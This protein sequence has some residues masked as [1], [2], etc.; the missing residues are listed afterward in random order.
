M[1]RKQLPHFRSEAVDG[2]QPAS[3]PAAADPRQQQQ[4]S[5]AAAPGKTP[6]PSQPPQPVAPVRQEG[7]TVRA[8]T[9]AETPVRQ[10]ERSVAA[11]APA[12]STVEAASVLSAQALESQLFD[13]LPER[14]LSSA[15]YR[16]YLKTLRGQIDDIL[17]ERD[18]E[19]NQK[20]IVKT[21][22]KLVEMR[23]D[24]EAR[25]WLR[26]AQIGKELLTAG[27]EGE[28]KLGEEL[29]TIAAANMRANMGLGFKANLDVYEQTGSESAGALIEAL[30][31]ASL[32]QP[33]AL[34]RPQDGSS[35]PELGQPEAAPAARSPM[36][37]LNRDEE[38]WAPMGWN[39]ERSD[40][41]P[42]SS[43]GPHSTDAR[44]TGSLAPSEP[45]PAAQAAGA[46][47]SDDDEA[48]GQ[49]VVEVSLTAEELAAVQRLLALSA[50]LDRKVAQ[51][52][53]KK[54]KKSKQ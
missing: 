47:T 12:G 40:S 8:D 23:D 54:P 20:R 19:L 2:R 22:Y 10:E 39:D 34:E 33:Q 1:K 38:D 11:D 43:P 25:S 44:Q 48:E 6:A 9:S 53:K 36:E 5:A 16:R 28:A 46:S 49:D 50:D 3:T 13:D 4:P 26:V 24:F 29:H 52:D 14:P 51:S 21:S 31:Q 37:W 7:G 41:E 35:A 17:A 32:Q 42:S 18:K 45:A 27:D 15:S 30:A